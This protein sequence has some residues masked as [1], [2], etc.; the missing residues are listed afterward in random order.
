[1]SSKKRALLARGIVLMVLILMI[2]AFIETIFVSPTILSAASG[3]KGYKF[4]VSIFPS[5][6]VCVCTEIDPSCIPCTDFDPEQ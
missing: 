4:Y 1:M 2:A 5:R 3:K 6:Y